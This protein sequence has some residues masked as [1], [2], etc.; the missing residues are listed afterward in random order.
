MTSSVNEPEGTVPVALL[1]GADRAGKLRAMIQC[2]PAERLGAGAGTMAVLM[3]GF[4]EPGF[5][6]RPT[7]STPFK[8]PRGALE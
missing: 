2:C 4:T 7:R 3:A 5:A 6:T 8:S 1:G